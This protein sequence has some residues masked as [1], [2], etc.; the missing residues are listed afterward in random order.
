VVTDSDGNRRLRMQWA[1]S[2]DRSVD[3]LQSV[4]ML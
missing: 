4:T 1:S 3:L 2:A